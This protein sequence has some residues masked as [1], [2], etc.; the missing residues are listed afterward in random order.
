MLFRN[1]ALALSISGEL[2]KG[3]SSAG[4]RG[5]PADYQNECTV[6]RKSFHFEAHSQARGFNGGVYGCFQP[7]F[8]APS[9]TGQT[10]NPHTDL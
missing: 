3:H 9:W 7:G 8:T 6:A 4:P 2:S 1:A 10:K 5:T